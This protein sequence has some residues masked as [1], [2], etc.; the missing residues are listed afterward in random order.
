MLTEI[1]TETQPVNSPAPIPLDVFSGPT[2]RARTDESEGIFRMPS[3]LPSTTNEIYRYNSNKT[4]IAASRSPLPSRTSSSRAARSS[5]GACRVAWRCC[6]VPCRC[7]VC[8]VRCAMCDVCVYRVAGSSPAIFVFPLPP[9]PP[10]L[11]PPHRC[12][13]FFLLTLLLL[14]LLSLGLLFLPSLRLFALPPLTASKKPLSS[15]TRR[16]SGAS[17]AG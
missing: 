1:I 7:A 2:I 3:D 13:Y 6:V 12:S 15:K 16:I 17:S 5:S 11:P 4:K 8:G 10:P 9:P 14:L